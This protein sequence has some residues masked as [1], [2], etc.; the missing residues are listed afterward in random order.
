[1]GRPPARPLS[2]QPEPEGR[3]GARPASG[4]RVQNRTWQ[5]R[6]QS[7]AG[8]FR[9]YLRQLRWAGAQPAGPGPE[10]WTTALRSRKIRVALVGIGNC[11]SSLV[12]GLTYYKDAPDD[13][14]TPGLMNVRLGGYH[15]R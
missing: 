13:V 4:N 8:E 9:T 15:V 2:S 14:E 11:A 5:G 1:M 7:K 3:I 10:Q 12:Q 6:N